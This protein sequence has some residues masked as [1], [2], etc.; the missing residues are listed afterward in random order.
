MLAILDIGG[1]MEL[2]PAE[3]KKEGRLQQPKWL[4]THL[5]LSRRQEFDS[6]EPQHP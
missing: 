2:G 1:F 5:L 3:L 4:S 6:S